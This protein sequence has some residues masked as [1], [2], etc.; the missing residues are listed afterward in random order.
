VQHGSVTVLHLFHTTTRRRT[1]RQPR[2]SVTLASTIALHYLPD[3]LDVAIPPV[4]RTRDTGFTFTRQDAVDFVTWLADEA[5]SYGMGFGLKNAKGESVAR[6]HL[7]AAT[8][9]GCMDNVCCAGLH[10]PIWRSL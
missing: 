7:R 10:C 9:A 3:N 2:C 1:Q 5:H 6:W 8:S 4:N